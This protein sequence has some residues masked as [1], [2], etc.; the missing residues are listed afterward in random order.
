MGGGGWGGVCDIILFMLYYSCSQSV[1]TKDFK[2]FPSNVNN[3]VVN[4]EKHSTVMEASITVHGSNYVPA[5]YR[6]HNQIPSK[7]NELF[8]LWHRLQEACQCH[9]ESYKSDE[10]MTKRDIT[11]IKY[12]KYKNGKMD[13]NIEC[14]YPNLKNLERYVKSGKLQTINK[15]NEIKDKIYMWAIGCTARAWSWS[16]SMPKKRYEEI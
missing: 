7:D 12:F 2:T 13:C 4:L 14:N 3:S 5:R 10:E 15:E 8:V 9:D 11:Y 16:T 1:K 6:E